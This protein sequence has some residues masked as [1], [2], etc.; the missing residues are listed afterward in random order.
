MAKLFLSIL[1]NSFAFFILLRYNKKNKN[2][3]QLLIFVP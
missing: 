3:A 2:N 1:S